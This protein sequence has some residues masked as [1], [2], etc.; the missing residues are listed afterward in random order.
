MVGGSSDVLGSLRMFSSFLPLGIDE[1]GRVDGWMD[2]RF[3]C[4]ILP[5]DDQETK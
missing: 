4:W 3:A 1:G 5:P 2:G